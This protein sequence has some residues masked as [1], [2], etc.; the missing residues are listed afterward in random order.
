MLKNSLLFEWVSRQKAPYEKAS[1][2]RAERALKHGVERGSH[3]K[4]REYL[5]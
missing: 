5:I 2:Q 3:Q 4:T 1:Y